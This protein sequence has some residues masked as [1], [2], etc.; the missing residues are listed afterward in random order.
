MRL[1]FLKN[2]FT[3]S[4]KKVSLKPAAVYKGAIGFKSGT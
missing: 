2:K 4:N 3:A 1:F